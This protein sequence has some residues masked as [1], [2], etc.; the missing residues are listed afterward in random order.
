MDSEPRGVRGWLTPLIA[1]SSNSIS[2]T[3]VFLVTAAAIFW[4]FLVAG[5]FG[6]GHG[7]DNPYTGILL[8][9]IVPAVFFLGLA[10]I[11]LGIWLRWRK[12]KGSGRV[13]PHE[14]PAISLKNPRIRRFAIF[15]L[16][17]TFANVIIASHFS[18][19]A[20]SY[21]DGVT[22][23]GLT[24]HKVMAPEY[25]AYQGS[26]HSRVECV[27][28]HIGPGA[29][30]F[31][32]SKLSGAHQVLAVAFNT[33]ERPIPSPVENLRPARDTCEACHWPQ[34]F[35]GE[36]LRVIPKYADDEAN[37]KTVTVLMMKIGG[38]TIGSDFALRGIHGAHVGP[39]VNI[40][41]AH[42]D[43][44]RQTIP[45][46][47]VANAGKE[48][49]E[50][51]LKGAKA[52]EVAKMAV[53]TMDCIDC[54]NRPTHAFELP[55]RGLDR[56][57]SNGE[58][59]PALPFLKKKGLELLKANYSSRE[60]ALRK[61]PEGIESFYRDHHPQIY[62]D[63]ADE[64]R[65]SARAVASIYERNVFPDMKL[66]WG[67]YINNIGHTDFTGCFRCHDDEHTSAGGKTI[68]QDC[69]TCH[70]MLATDEQSPKILTD[71]GLKQ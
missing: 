52:E 42:S 67:T 19:T 66:G 14:V 53:R 23:C 70:E 46:V 27:R 13:V 57:L 3:G 58:A 11:P 61:I 5:S 43:R 36:R 8:F 60:E 51:S 12:E 37:T 16:V 71:L 28:C 9:I 54:H 6:S 39:G 20:V 18:Y 65:R 34:K 45:W 1:L 21:M 48:T 26:P 32:K 15:L 38:G 68:S 33:Y 24:C 10:L 2:A 35:G 31:V 64:V 22:F 7:A 4:V 41:Y 25:S 62:R 29:S 49:V 47:Q 55:E 40:R 69:S 56:V 50:Y 63:K 59:S 17:T 44:Q 30:W